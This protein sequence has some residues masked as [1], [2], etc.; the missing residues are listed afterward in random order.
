MKRWTRLLPLTAMA[1][2]L[3]LA[4]AAAQ[5]AAP[6]APKGI[7]KIQHIVVIYLENHSFDDL[8]G[9]FP[10]ADGLANAGK[11][12]LQVDLQNKPYKTLP[13]VIDAS[14]KPP[15]PDPRFPASLPNRPFFIGKYVPLDKK[16]PSPIHAYLHEIAQIN[17][18]KMNKFVSEGDT[19]AMV[20]GYNEGSKLA[21]WR[22]AKEFTLSD[23]FFHA[24]FGGSFLNHFWTICACTPVYK[25]APQ[26]MR[27]TF[28]P[29][30]H[31]TKDGQVLPDPEGHIVNTSFTV[32]NP[33][34]PSITDK[35][36]LVP[37]QTMKTIGDMLSEKGI[38][39]AWYSGGW[40]DA[41]AG[42]AAPDFQFHHQPFAY[43]ANYADGTDAKKQHLLD[44]VELIAAI[45][46][47]DIPSVVFWKPIGELNEHPGYADTISGDEHMAEVIEKIRKSP[48]WK[49]TVIIVTYD[50]NGGMWDHVAPPKADKWG[51]GSRVPTVIISPFAKRHHVD[52]TIYDTTSILKLIETRYGL[53]PLGERDAKAN[54]LTHALNLGGK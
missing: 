22:Y 38:S 34:P 45:D 2:A 41:L 28:G 20:M 17:G 19:G 43:F 27:S 37:P 10:G 39:W 11:R 33:H 36:L 5:Q 40:N 1:L 52:H 15:A 9:K 12:S 24:A 31:F 3:G 4:S 49:S 30:G 51:P 44:E 47:G 29:D 46:K 8:F 54:N 32:F 48:L 25:D 7:E 21:L 16:Y 14:L 26:S 13:P 23:H 35:T 18:G 6:K 42:K 53:P 50:E